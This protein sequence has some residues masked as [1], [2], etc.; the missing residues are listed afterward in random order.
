MFM[1]ELYT[2]SLFKNIF[3]FVFYFKIVV[4]ETDDKKTK[5]YGTIGKTSNNQWVPQIRVTH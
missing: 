4:P 3:L 2:L 5:M 1:N